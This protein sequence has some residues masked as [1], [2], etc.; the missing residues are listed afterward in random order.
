MKRLRVGSTSLAL[1]T[2]WLNG[3][4]AAAEPDLDDVRGRQHA[5]ASLD[6][7]SLPGEMESCS[8]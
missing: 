5:S 4:A 8:R 6:E 7:K 3:S 2:R 1:R